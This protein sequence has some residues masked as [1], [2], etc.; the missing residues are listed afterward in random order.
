[1]AVWYTAIDAWDGLKY[2]MITYP[3]RHFL[4]MRGL[5][6][7][8]PGLLLGDFETIG[9]YLPLFVWLNALIATV[10]LVWAAVLVVAMTLLFFAKGSVRPSGI[11]MGVAVLSAILLSAALTGYLRECKT[12][13]RACQG[14]ASLSWP[15]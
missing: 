14:T 9:V 3:S 15:A 2:S 8:S 13:R 10:S 6:F 7:P 5:P 11:H 4:A 1:M 12:S